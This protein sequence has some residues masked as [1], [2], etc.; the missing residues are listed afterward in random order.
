MI[1]LALR[2]AR[3]VERRALDGTVLNRFKTI[4]TPD[5]IALG[6]DGSVY[7]MGHGGWV[8]RFAADGV[9][10]DTWALP[11]DD[12]TPQDLAVDGAGRVYVAWQR[13]G[14][15][16]AHLHQGG[17]VWVRARRRHAAERRPAGGCRVVPDKRAAP[18]AIPLGGR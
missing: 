6:P 3:I 5:A 7:V 2:G 11:D 10:L 17:G 13:P 12:R 18:G 9:A 1:A 4:D 16:G 15:L 14:A 8:T